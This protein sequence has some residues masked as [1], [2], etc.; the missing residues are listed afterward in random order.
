MK[1]LKKQLAGFEKQTDS[2]SLP[3][4]AWA[5]TPAFQTFAVEMA[6]SAHIPRF[7]RKAS[8]SNT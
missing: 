8:R 5:S 2:L 7:G 3:V 4:P 1:S 6:S